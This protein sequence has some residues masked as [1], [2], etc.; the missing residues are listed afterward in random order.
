MASTQPEKPSGL[1]QPGRQELPV[2][3]PL[4]TRAEFSVYSKLA[5]NLEAGGIWGMGWGWG[6]CGRWV[7]P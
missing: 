2:L 7:C 6:L 5:A 1:K 4:L 3:T